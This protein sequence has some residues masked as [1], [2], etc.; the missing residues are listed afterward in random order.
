MSIDSQTLTDLVEALIAR[1]ERERL[2]TMLIG[3]VERFDPVKKSVD[4]QPAILERRPNG[5]YRKIPLLINVPYRFAN[6]AT[7]SIELPIAPGDPV[8]IE[9]LRQP[10]DQWLLKGGAGVREPLNVRYDLSQAVASAGPRPFAGSDPP[11]STDS[12]VIR[13]K[14]NSTSVSLKPGGVTEIDGA[15]EIRLGTGATD[16]VALAALVLAELQQIQ[17][18]FNAHTHTHGAGPGITAVP[19]PQ[20]PPPASVAATKTR[21]E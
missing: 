18:A 16:F 7:H 12:L 1:Y 3:I 5:E 17:S 4:V 15:T 11:A 8:L 9:V 14:D 20:L 2:W 10:Y 21:A 6:C 19:A 13:A